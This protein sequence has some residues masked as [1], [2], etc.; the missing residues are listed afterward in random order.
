MKTVGN[1]DF[2]IAH[3]IAQDQCIACS[4]SARIGFQS[5]A[6]SHVGSRMFFREKVI[7]DYHEWWPM[8]RLLGDGKALVNAERYSFT[9][10]AHTRMVY[11]ALRE[12]GIT[13]FD[14]TRNHRNE[15]EPD[16]SYLLAEFRKSYEQYRRMRDRICDYKW[17]QLKQT[18][19]AYL[20]FCEAFGFAVEWDLN[21]DQ[22]KE[23]KA[24]VA[25]YKKLRELKKFRNRLVEGRP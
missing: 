16:P 23:L 20:N 13:A 25:H 14:V 2:V 22:W 18:R 5:G 24:R 1:Y 11:S 19:Q 12:A 21:E 8:A 3:W 17:N 7:F 6:V 10:S 9:T 15:L 4:P